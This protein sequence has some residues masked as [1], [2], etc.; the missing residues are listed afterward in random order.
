MIDVSVIYVNF[1][2]SSYLEESVASFIKN[3]SGFSY[4]LVVVDNSGSETEKEK[5]NHLSKTYNLKSV[6]VKNEGFGAAC[7]EGAKI[8]NGRYLFF[9]NCDTVIKDNSVFIL[10][11]FLI[12]NPEVAIVG[13]NL[14]SMDDGPNLSFSLEEKNLVNEKKQYQLKNFTRNKTTY[15]STGK[16]LE[17]EGFVSGAALMIRKEVFDKIGGFNKRIF[18]YAEEAY[19]CY[20][21]RHKL[22]LKVFNV[23]DAKIVH[24]EGKSFNVSEIRLT[25]SCEGNYQYY[26]LIFGEEEAKKYLAMMCKVY[27]K[28]HMLS[29]ITFNFK[30]ASKFKLFLKVYQRKKLEV[31]NG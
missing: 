18:L 25:Y 11:E 12:L 15:N 30:K 4:E 7:N 5:I 14:I 16:P 29:L 9:L 17:I 2:T 21:V 20:L 23:P 3:S 10:C 8:A 19:L 31:T 28:L 6:F 24:L 22:G 26:K 27:K 13:P 1:N